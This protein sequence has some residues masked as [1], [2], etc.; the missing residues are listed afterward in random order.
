LHQYISYPLLDINRQIQQGKAVLAIFDFTIPKNYTPLK[1]ASK[2]HGFGGFKT[3]FRITLRICFLLE[4][5]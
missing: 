1:I 3:N 5:I 4:K 2:I